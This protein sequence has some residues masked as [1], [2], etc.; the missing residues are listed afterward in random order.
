MASCVGTWFNSSSWKTCSSAPLQMTLRRVLDKDRFGDY[1]EQISPL[2]ICR[3][4][5]R[6]IGVAAEQ[7]AVRCGVLRC[8]L[9]RA[10]L[11]A[12]EGS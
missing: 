7:R 2:T 11:Q 6:P 12:S 5:P 4:S 9:V 8:S 3:W 1:T 10:A